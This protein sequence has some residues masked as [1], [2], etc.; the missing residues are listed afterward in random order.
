MFA[1]SSCNQNAQKNINLSVLWNNNGLQDLWSYE[2]N[3][4]TAR[5]NRRSCSVK[6][7]VPKNF[8]IFTGK[9]L[10]WSLFLINLPKGLQ[11]QWKETSTLVFSCAYCE[12]F[13]NT[14][15]EYLR[16]AVSE[17]LRF[18]IFKNGK[19]TLFLQAIFL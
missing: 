4:G 19:W 7:G 1:F 15:F 13:K 8:T 17:R 11:L 14:Y 2:E 18:Y 3:Y 12:I 6:R 9:H 10:C 5:S 16:T